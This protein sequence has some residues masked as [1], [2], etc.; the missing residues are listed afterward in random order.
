MS[1][2]ID[3][4]KRDME[5]SHKVLLERLFPNVSTSN[6]NHKDHEAWLHDFAGQIKAKVEV[7]NDDDDSE[8][9]LKKQVAHYKTVL[10]Q[11][12]RV[13]ITRFKA[14]EPLDGYTEL[15]QIQFNK[16]IC[17]VKT[18]RSST[19]STR[20]VVMLNCIVRVHD[21]WHCIGLVWDWANTLE[22]LAVQV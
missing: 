13:T 11:T 6:K 19:W 2:A 5:S 21:R 10:D 8:E 22:H 3:K 18:E 12:V 17:L 16:L 1:E 14:L 9:Q 15:A 4:S 7:K 20:L